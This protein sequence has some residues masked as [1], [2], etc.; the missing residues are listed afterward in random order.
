MAMIS[1]VTGC[2]GDYLYSQVAMV[3]TYTVTGCYVDDLYS[4]RLLW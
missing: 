4:Y 2:P 3:M 1:T